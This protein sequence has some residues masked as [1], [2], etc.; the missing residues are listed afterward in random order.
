MKNKQNNYRSEKKRVDALEALGPKEPEEKQ[1]E[2]VKEDKKQQIK[3][4][5]KL[6][7]KKASE[8]IAEIYN[9]SKQIDFNR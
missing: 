8:K 7:L 2:V 5:N 1:I 3:S 6:L 9:I 4:D